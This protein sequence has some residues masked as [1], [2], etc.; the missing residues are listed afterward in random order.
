MT[1]STSSTYQWISRAVNEIAAERGVAVSR[2]FATWLLAFVHEM[3]I[4]QALDLTDTG[5]GDGGGDG[6][7]DGWFQDDEA[8]V[9]HLW[10]C[11]WTDDGGRRFDRKLGDALIDGYNALLKPRAAKTIGQKF[12][13]LSATFRNA[14]ERGYEVSLNLGIPTVLPPKS[15]ET[16]KQKLLSSSARSILEPT[17]NT[18]DAEHLH[19]LYRDQ[20]PDTQTLSGVKVEFKLAN[21]EL[22]TLSSNT[23]LPKG[24]KAFVVN[25]LG[26]SLGQQVK[27]HGSQ[28]FSMNV[29]YALNRGLK[30]I[31][32]IYRTLES[33]AEAPF[34]WFYN[35]G[36]TILADECKVERVGGRPNL[37]VENPQVVNGCQTVSAFYNR[38][39]SFG[40]AGVSVLVRIIIPPSGPDRDKQAQLISENTNTQSQVLARD[41]RT[42]DPVHRDIA[43]MLNQ[44]SPP[45]FYAVKR[46]QWEM[47]RKKDLPKYQNRVLDMERLAQSFEMQ[48]KPAEALTKKGSLFEDAKVYSS[49]FTGSRTAA[50]YLFPEI[51]R[52]YF[53]DIWHR[54]NCS[55]IQTLCGEQMSDDVIVRLLKAKGQIVSHSVAL[56]IK[57]FQAEGLWTPN[58]AQLAFAVLVSDGA[59]LEPWM[60]HLGRAFFQMQEKLDELNSVDP[61]GTTLKKYL[62]RGEQASLK[63]LWNGIVSG[64]GL[65]M[66]KNWR[67]RIIQEISKGEKGE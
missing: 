46:G 36:I 44:L 11:K 52:R 54:K 21:A 33:D 28:L 62:E 19:A 42:N 29:R 14:I 47:R 26:E 8:Q 43:A 31:E 51:C 15:F 23:G 66:G 35:N 34:F 39:G 40:H 48:E 59:S 63:E 1:S 27:A 45:W 30:R 9:F 12:A 10:Q 22:M 32:R 5:V 57:L 58:S 41:L 55:L 53:E 20:N 49:I 50:D 4:D 24:W 16:I 17:I 3:D 37:V 6:G 13:S 2:A 25:V 18:Y 65:W 38:L 67:K 64:A 7:I 56:T 61:V 60:R